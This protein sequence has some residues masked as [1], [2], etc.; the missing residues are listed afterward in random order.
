MDGRDIGVIGE[1]HPRWRQAYELPHAPVLF[2]IELDAAL[3]R[4]V[5]RAEPVARHQPA[6]RDVALVV[7]DSAEHDALIDA[8]KA[9]PSGH[10]RSAILF[11][12]YKP[13]SPT[14]DI[15]PGERSLA[16]RLELLDPDATWTDERIETVKQAAIDRATRAVGARLRA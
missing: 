14:G 15:G 1:L 5:P 2:E 4:P 12:V 16:V 6:W 13:S 3:D 8:L 10:V 7:P 11:D 9:D